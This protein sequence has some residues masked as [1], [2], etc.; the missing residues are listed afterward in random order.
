MS[1][2]LT[3]TGH[4]AQTLF[5]LRRFSGKAI[6]LGDSLEVIVSRRLAFGLEPCFSGFSHMATTRSLSKYVPEEFL[7]VLAIAYSSS[8]G[9]ICNASGFSDSGG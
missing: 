7:Y 5:F 2:T 9:S 3:T 8:H 6:G 4:K 1:S